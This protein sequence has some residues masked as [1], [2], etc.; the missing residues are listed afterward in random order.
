MDLTQI[1]IVDA[2][3]VVLL[4]LGIMGGLRRGLIKQAVLLVGLV[5]ILVISFY[6]RGPISTY[7][8]KHLPF[9][10]F[11]G[12][13]KG[14]SVLNILLYEVIAFLIVFSILYLVLRVL[15]KISGIIES[16][17]KAT[18]ILGFFSRIGGAIVGFIESY[19]IVFIILFIINQPFVNI[20]GVE[21]S[22]L[23]NTILNKTPILSPAVKDT[24][25]VIDEIYNLKDTYKNNG[26]EFNQKAIE[27]FIKYDIVSEE[28]INYLR[29]K[30]KLE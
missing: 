4:I 26:K 5:A 30:G 3:I 9:F 12:L 15:L 11:G 2:L 8:Y 25:K 10:S 16:I 28:N 18:I 23:T 19:I 27:L 20:K 1:S 21:E 13:F 6:L 17:L 24:K 29:E 22:K 7:M 14:V